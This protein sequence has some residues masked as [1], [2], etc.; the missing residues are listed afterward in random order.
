MR[1]ARYIM[2]AAS[3]LALCA[4]QIAQAQTA[5]TLL[6]VLSED[7]DDDGKACGVTSEG[8]AASIRSAMRY[9]RI[10]EDWREIPDAYVYVATTTL[11]VREICFVSYNVRVHK[12][13]GGDLEGMGE[14]FGRMVFCD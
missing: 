12:Y 10:A 2:L 5:P 9:N 1:T 7:V 3:A 14:V 6:K 4:S 8:N 11:P 13:Q